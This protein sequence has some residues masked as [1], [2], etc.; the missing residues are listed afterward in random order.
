MPTP[1]ATPLTLPAEL[2]VDLPAAGDTPNVLW[3]SFEHGGGD[4]GVGMSTADADAVLFTSGGE[5]LQPQQETPTGGGFLYLYSVNPGTYYLA[6]LS[7][8]MSKE[9]G[10]DFLANPVGAGAVSGVTYGIAALSGGVL[11]PTDYQTISLPFNGQVSTSG[12][13]AWLRFTHASSSPVVVIGGDPE[14]ARLGL[15]RGDDGS[16]VTGENDPWAAPPS[17]RFVTYPAFGGAL[18][19]VFLCVAAGSGADFNNGFD[20][21]GQAGEVTLTL[22]ID[23]AA[24][25]D[26]STALVRDDFDGPAGDNIHG[27]ALPVADGVVGAGSWFDGYESYDDLM[28]KLAG[29][30]WAAVSPGAFVAGQA[31]TSISWSATLPGLKGCDELTL[32]IGFRFLRDRSNSVG[33]RFEYP[34]FGGEAAYLESRRKVSVSAGRTGSGDG[35]YVQAATS[36][37]DVYSADT[38]IVLDQQH[39]LA[40]RWVADRLQVSLDGTVLVDEPQTERFLGADK[41]T[42]G[43]PELTVVSLEGNEIDFVELRMANGPVVRPEFWTAFVGSYEAA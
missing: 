8:S 19:D 20:V 33:L 27:R 2:V 3:Y 34:R 5:V 1:I 36:V 38:P 14:A 25:R 6:L 26:K 41:Y 35:G 42:V 39:V 15:F 23:S 31:E 28:S 13:L 22:A 9:T 11:P 43:A 7:Y 32:T 21:S 18:G 37:E 4:L 29:G 30:G 10:S 16:V 12:G 17:P 40:M 24:P